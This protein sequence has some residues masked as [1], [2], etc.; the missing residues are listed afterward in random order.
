MDEGVPDEDMDAGVS[1]DSGIPQIYVDYLASVA[2][3]MPPN[4]AL[5]R[6]TYEAGGPCWT[7][8]LPS[9]ASRRATPAYSLFAWRIQAPSNAPP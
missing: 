3:V 5:T 2:A 9:R 6:A 1:S 8:M 7:Q 4:S